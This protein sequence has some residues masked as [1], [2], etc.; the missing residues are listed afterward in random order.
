MG[1]QKILEPIAHIYTP[2]PT[3]FGVPRQ[4]SLV[5]ALVSE[6]RFEEKYRDIAS[7]RSLE[8]FD[9]LWLIW[10][11]S[12]NDR[13]GW[14][15]TVRPPVLGGT[16]RMGVF[17]T[18]SSFRPNGLGLSSVRLLRVETDATYEQGPKGPMLYVAGTDMVDGTPIYDIK[19]YIPAWD[20]HAEARSGWRDGVVWPELEVYIPQ[21]ELCKIPF[22]MRKGLLQILRQDPRPAYTREGQES[23]VFWTPVREFAIQFTVSQNRLEVVC[24]TRLSLAQMKQLKETGSL[25]EFAD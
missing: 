7:V 17:A 9:Y 2:Y 10:G 1:D 6:I 13:E 3:K 24:I 14:S 19:P 15:P 12:H 11:F 4:P 25:E 18:R 21:E 8:G 22:D 16:K 23:R 5:D 20:S